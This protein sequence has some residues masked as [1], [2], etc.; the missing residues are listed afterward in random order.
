MEWSFRKENF[1]KISSYKMLLTPL[2]FELLTPSFQI[3]WQ[4]FIDISPQFKAYSNKWVSEFCSPSCS[5]V[6]SLHARYYSWNEL[7]PKREKKSLATLTYLTPKGHWSSKIPSPC[8]HTLSLDK[9]ISHTFK[10][11]WDTLLLS[12]HPHS[13]S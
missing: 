7:L 4:L 5:D 10:M 1:F 3:L 8:R 12:F 11:H 9:L 13:F 6:A 2:Y